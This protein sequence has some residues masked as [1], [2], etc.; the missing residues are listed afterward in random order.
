MDAS[1]L[2][3]FFVHFLIVFKA[4]ITSVPDILTQLKSIHEALGTEMD[5]AGRMLVFTPGVI[6]SK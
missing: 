4:L 2:S 5:E 6:S 3:G 1:P